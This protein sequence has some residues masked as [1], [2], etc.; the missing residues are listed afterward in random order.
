[1]IYREWM[2]NRCMG[3]KSKSINLPNNHLLINPLY[4]YIT[5][6]VNTLAVAYHILNRI[7]NDEKKGGK[8]SALMDFCCSVGMYSHPFSLAKLP[9]SSSVEPKPEQNRLWL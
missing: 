4:S 6:H 3:E 7:A 5:V 1:M 8:K 2:M 9:T